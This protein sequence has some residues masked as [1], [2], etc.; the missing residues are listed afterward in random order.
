M[1]KLIIMF[2]ML[3]ILT[4]L[5]N[6]ATQNIF[7]LNLE[8]D[9]GEI[10]LESMQI[11]SSKDRI[12]NIPGGYV[13]EILDFDKNRLNV[14]F[15]DIPLKLIY[16][17]FDEKTEEAVSGGMIELNQTKFNLKLPYYE[18]AKEIIIY[19]KDFNK[20][21]TIDVSSYAKTIPKEPE[22]KPKIE[23]EKEE[24]IKKIPETEKKP[25]NNTVF[26]IFGI[27]AFII[28]LFIIIKIIRSKKTNY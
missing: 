11:E 25:T 19:D 13:A 23:E 24:P 4:N 12:D 10:I 5:V 27:I 21:L 6:A 22:E 7:N 17:K 3:F 8:Y 1:R 18:N 2:I 16:D 28:L 9:N 26:I 20:K 15:F 14:T